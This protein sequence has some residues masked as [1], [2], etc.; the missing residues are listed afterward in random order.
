MIG[1]VRR[2]VADRL[3]ETPVAGAAWFVRDVVEGIY[4]RATEANR[5]RRRAGAA[6]VMYHGVTPAL[7][8]PLV[9]GAHISAALFRAQ[10]RYLRK[11]Y[12]IVPLAELVDCLERGQDP[13]DD[14]AVL[15]FDDGYRNNLTCALEICR[16]EGDLPMS[17]FVVTDF[18]GTRTTFWTAQVMMASLH[19]KFA[20]LRIPVVDRGGVSW[21]KQPARTRRE[22]ANLYWRM[23]PALKALDA[24]TRAPVLEEFFA[25][26]GAGEV[27]EIRSRFPSFDW[28][29]WDETRE[30]ARSGVD[31][32]SHTRTHAYL[33]ADLG[34]A[35]LRDEIFQSRDRI[36]AELGGPPAHFAYPNGTRAD[37]CD[38]SEAL[39]REAGYRCALT[40]EGGTVRRGD[41]A[42]ELLRLTNCV[43]SLPRFRLANSGGGPAR[44]SSSAVSAALPRD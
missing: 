34:A 21:Q 19:G 32:G 39:L 14:W 22:R 31:V 1:A 43:N 20:E 8:D 27:A 25:Q 41:N 18:I 30:L 9:E 38:L 35:R 17:V 5:R 10:L 12:R 44:P 15:S 36:A 24:S 13:A 37:F 23:L 16:E 29:T 6:V 7:V 26:F 2:R 42:F 3:R 28:L 40:T 11:H 33:R 4:A